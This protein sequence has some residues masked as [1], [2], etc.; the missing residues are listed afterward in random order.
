MPF[1]YRLRFEDRQEVLRSALQSNQAGIWTAVPGIIQKVNLTA[2]TVEVQPSIQALVTGA[3]QQ[4]QFTNLPVC[5][6][7]PIYFP[8][9]GGYTMTYPIKAG[10]EC[11]LVFSSRCIDSWWDQGGVQPQRELR[12]HDLSDGFALVGPFSQ[13]TKIANVSTN[14][15]QM[16]SDDGKNY[17]EIDTD[18]KK[19]TTI[20][21]GT[22]MVINDND[23][24]ITMIGELHVSKNVIAGFGGSD[25]VT[26]QGH[27]HSQGPD[28]HGDGEV[29]VNPP[30]PG[31]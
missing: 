30:T 17:V 8:R 31:T 23:N 12:M 20:V 29:P 21:G 25:S 15:V 11:L 10:D 5:P 22:S 2:L 19:L 4:K 16:R 1:D 6:D 18:N 26:L 14:T 24:T 3:N 13:K 28:S 7:V 27:V 9:G